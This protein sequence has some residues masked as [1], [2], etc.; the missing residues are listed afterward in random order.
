MLRYFPQATTW[1]LSLLVVATS[2]LIPATARPAQAA[3]TDTPTPVVTD[4]VEEWAVGAGLLYWAS[5]CYADEFNPF[6]ILKRKPTGGGTERTLE[7][8]EDFSLCI[9]YQNLLS[10]DDGLYY[11]DSSQ[12]RIERMPLGEPYTPQVVKALTNAQ[13]PNAGK[14]F[15]EAAGYLYWLN[16]SNKIFR[17]HKDGSGEV[18]TVADTTATPT[19]V[20]VV[21]N[22]LYWAESTG[23][24]SISL[25]CG[26]L[27]CTSSKGNFINLGANTSA[28]G[29]LYQ[30][31]GG[32]RGDYRIYWVQ[33][34]SSGANNDYQI[35]YQQCNPIVVCNILPPLPLTAQNQSAP[36]AENSPD[37]TT[38]SVQFYAA[39]TNWRIGN[40]I[41]VNNNLYWTEADFSTVSNN[42]GDV[43]RKAYNATGLGADTIATGQ[44]KMDAR[45]YT[46]NGNLFFARQSIGIY[47]LSLNA[48]A[49]VRDFSADGLEV[50]QAIQNLAN[51]APL[52]ADKLT[53]VRVYGKQI[54][55]P[56][57]P[58]VEARLIGIK[59]DLPLPGS[60]LRPIN[61]VRALTTGG[62]FDR[63]RLNDGW[64]FLLPAS[65]I[66]AGNVSLQVEIDPRQ[67][68]TDPNRSNNS[69]A[70][71]IAFQKQPP[72]CVW[73]VPVRTHTPLPSTNDPNFWSMV[74]HF[75]RRWPIPDT[76]I[77]RDT[78]PV[79]ELQ[80]CW[81]GPFPYP[82]HGPYELEDGWSITNGP[83][84]RDKVI[85]S[86]WGRAL[87]SFNPD[88]CDNIGAPVHFMGMVHPDAN[89]GG[90]AGYASTISNQSW[91]Q[92]PDHTPNP[93]PAGWNQL[94]EG[95]TMAQELAHNFGRKH[96][97]CGSPD[98]VD[99][100][101][102]YPPCQIAN[103]GA[104]SYYGFDV[105]TL[106]PIR[107][108][109]TADF[110]SYASRSWVSDYTWR[111]LLNAFAASSVAATSANA[112]AVTAEG[113]SVFVT[114]LIDTENNRGEIS[115]V[116]VLPT[117]SV[118]PA[119]RQT[120]SLQA[121][122][123][124]HASAPQAVYKLRLLDA[125]GTIL[126]ER[127]LT[128][129]ELDDHSAESADAIF[130][131]LF[132]KPSGTVATIQLLADSTVIDTVSPGVNPPTVAI[133][134][135]TGGALI[136]NT[137]TVHWTASDP[138]VDDRLL[139]TVQYS[140]DNG[141]SWHTL[142]L[143]LNGTPDPNNTLTLTDLGSL[144]G[145]AP[146]AALIRV[147]ASDGYN[148]A[149]A[150]SQPFT[151]K[152]R[153][154][155]PVILTPGAGQTVVAGPPVL[156]QGSATDA[157]DGG[158]PASALKWQTD[159][160]NQ[161]TGPALTAAGLA[162]GAHSA[163]LSATDSNS[164][165]VTATVAFNVAPL[166]IPL[167]TAPILDGNCD[168]ETYA[169]G[170]TLQ[171]KPYSSGDQA[172]VRLLR[173]NDHLWACFSGLQLGA[174]APGA[175][176]GLRADIDNSRDPL[177]QA[178]DAGFFVGEDGDVLTT[179][180]D[181]AGNFASPGPGGLVAQVS[182]GVGSWSAE[183]RI[184]KT[185]LGGWDHLVGLNFGH[186]WVGSQGDD[187]LW[188]YRSEWNK[189]NTWATTALGSQPV[190][191]ALSPFTATVLAPPFTMTVTGSS[192]ISGTQVLWNGIALPTTF[193]DG[194]QLTTQVGDAQLN[195]ATVVQV[196]TRSPAPGNFVSNALPFVVA[197]TTPAITSLS[198]STVVA[199]NPTLTLTVDG[200]GFA[201]DAQI[202]WNGNPLTTQF[203][204]PTQVKVQ[205]DAGLL[206]NG[207]IVGVAVRNQLPDARISSSAVFEIQP[208]LTNNSNLYLPLITR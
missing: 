196:T 118:P 89:N 27:P 42:N 59:N 72:V 14:A 193:V 37:S 87:L 2:L 152:N 144:H 54:S 123:L 132:A 200:T 153:P 174:L 203:V 3:P 101:Y 166:S 55:G 1:L 204:S 28:H 159:G 131:D 192:F 24:Y 206:A 82:C 188:P 147:L 60:P 66:A 102:P 181:G 98:N 61:G 151:L 175:F 110:M 197:A 11:F 189:P 58:N 162:P 104:T 96:V 142:A 94:R 156:L 30:S 13:L 91:V 170:S 70:Q 65:W 73:T 161:G 97:N 195:S 120:L 108:D 111:A 22:T 115:V 201:A 83:P 9:N 191:T 114:G 160:V 44:S 53:Y 74:S 38:A 41:L 141:G 90:A 85:V 12:Q 183:L 205:I 75:N 149:L 6:A 168:D 16:F 126:V 207:Q 139:F 68:H 113:D 112:A 140:H 109:Q 129:T 122:G 32:I 163:A 106:Q 78:S 39:T 107:P 186:Y 19:D 103:V 52:V 50:T 95:S 125:N 158:L 57:A 86:L 100:S 26:T 154:P 40:L 134:Q 130:S 182:A 145:S 194:E 127:T 77:Y 155:E 117:A 4:F 178:T 202:L 176:A 10:A 56:S 116:L 185:T 148:T 84:D 190:I 8:I 45:I 43:K 121:A 81:W 79:E 157:E 80:V 143:N 33:R 135:P 47:S 167:A 136:D 165:T 138:D 69:I 180:G 49:I 51:N 199:G 67:I 23:I 173:S 71:T 64:Y 31:L 99:S 63:A 172:S 184:D 34:T 124:D 198:P 93:V 25:T 5:N 76:W 35:R 92:L 146:S 179:A 36:T 62:S 133:Q 7:S 17:M 137:L 29:L 187:Y 15:I 105:T 21:G 119:T 169:S 171:L 208:K 128:L 88:A 48:S 18:E 164:Q 177:A 20:M 46:A 150:T